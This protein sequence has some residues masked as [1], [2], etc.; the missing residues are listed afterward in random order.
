[1]PSANRMSKARPAVTASARGWG[2][3]GEQF[4]AERDQ[5]Q[6][7]QA[8]QAQSQA[9]FHSRRITP[10]AAEGYRSADLQRQEQAQAIDE[11]PRRFA[12]QD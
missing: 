8:S 4:H 10:P 7:E 2:G 1:M 3:R 12:D 6:P 5:A 11:A 9:G